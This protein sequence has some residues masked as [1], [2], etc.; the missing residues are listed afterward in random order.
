MQ[1]KVYLDHS[2][3]TPT[4]KRVLNKMLPFFCDKFGNPSSTHNFGV[5]PR[6]TV[7]KAREQI[8]AF[9][10][11]KNYE[12]IFTSGATEADN[13]AIKGVV[14]H[15]LSQGKKL[16]DLHIISSQIEHPAILEPLRDLKK[17]G[18][19]VTFLP[20]N[21][22]G[23]VQV[24]KLR[25]AITGKTI[26]VTIMYVNNEVGTIQPIAAMGQ[27]IKTLNLKRKQPILFHT[28]AVQ[29]LNYTNC[30]VKQLNVDLLSLS[31]H[32][33]YGPKG[34]GALYVRENTPLVPQQLGGHQEYN[35]RAGTLPAPLMVGLG[36]AVNLIKKDKPVNA[37][38]KKLRN[39]LKNEILKNIDGVRINGDM[40]K[41]VP[42]NLNVCFRKAE[43]ESIM[44]MLDMAGIAVSTGS[45][46][47]SGSLDPSH[48]LLAMNIPKDIIHGSIRFTLGRGTTKADIDYTLKKLK[49]VIEKLRKIAP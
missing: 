18:L 12:V 40:N 41:R 32:K 5:L 38:I 16:K 45:A 10:H 13:L 17:K 15:Y 46:C 34:I 43:G 36:E 31:G 4:D 26:L 27:V 9:L 24:S 48:V 30:N 22:N 35:I 44:M 7:E 37:R 29:A 42:S 47:S 20:V 3:T 11:C 1:K 39:Y 8:S 28:D 14:D 21:R 25:K 49:E 6:K 2:A 19:K 33:I 23:L